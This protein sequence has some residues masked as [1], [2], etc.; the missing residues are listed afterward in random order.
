MAREAAVYGLGCAVVVRH[1]RG[2]ER[3]VTVGRY[4]KTWA[5]SR[6]RLLRAESDTHPQ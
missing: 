2:R 1:A 5:C 3:P 4:T 6:G